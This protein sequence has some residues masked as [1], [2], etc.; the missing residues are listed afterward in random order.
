MF[1]KGFKKFKSKKKR[2]KN[3]AEKNTSL[4][5]AKI[6]NVWSSTALVLSEMV[7]V[8]V[9]VIVLIVRIM[10]IIRKKESCRWK[11]RE[12]KIRTWK[13]WEKSRIKMEVVFWLTKKILVIVEGVSVCRSIAVVIL[14]GKV[15]MVI[16][17]VRIA[18]ILKTNFSFYYLFIVY[19]WE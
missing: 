18:I 11:L 17:I 5:T 19:F 9:I 7:I 2:S 4:A 15:V 14:L 13:N 12:K 3:K 1:F 16:V 10:K 8:Q 6:Q